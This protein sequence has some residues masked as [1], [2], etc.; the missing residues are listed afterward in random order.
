MQSVGPVRRRSY[1]L[2]WEDL[3][4]WANDHGLAANTLNQ[5]DHAVTNKLNFMFFGCDV[6][7]A[8]TPLA[9]VRFYR[10]DVPRTT[11]LVR[12]SEALKGYRKLDPPRGRLP[13][14]FPM[15]CR[16]IQKLWLNHKQ[17]GMWLVMV[18]ALCARPGEVMKLRKGDLVEQ[19]QCVPTG[20]SS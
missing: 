17:V 14:P 16:V 11:M 20:L 3:K 7:D 18:W 6:A 5:I 4:D 1:Q 19:F 2:A 9:A 10:Q 12:A 15:L 13:L 8:M